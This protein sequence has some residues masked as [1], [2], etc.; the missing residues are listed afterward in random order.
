[1]RKLVI[2]AIILAAVSM[3]AAGSYL[4]VATVTGNVE[5]HEQSGVEMIEQGDAATSSSGPKEML[6]S[7][8]PLD[9]ETDSGIWLERATREGGGFTNSFTLAPD[10]GN[11]LQVY[12][13]NHN[14]SRKVIVKVMEE[15]SGMD[16]DYE[17]VAPGKQLT[18]R[19]RMADGSGVAGEWK[20]QV[21]SRDGHALNVD[22]AV[23]QLNQSEAAEQGR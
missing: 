17:D 5:V 19:F 3:L 7:T 11:E 13:H 8:E 9:D 15:T 6:S 10:N 18:R 22:V 16:F 1:M 23:R 20:V 4:V 12:V 2:T 21:T 14:A